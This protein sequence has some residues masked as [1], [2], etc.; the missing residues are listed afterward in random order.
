MEIVTLDESL[1][2]VTAP[3]V[4]D[5]RVSLSSLKAVDQMPDVS[6]AKDELLSFMTKN[7]PMFVA[8][9][10]EEIIG[11]LICKVEDFIVW[12]EQ[13]YVRADYRRRGVASRLFD[14][15][16]ALAQSMGEDT[17]FNNVHP[18][19]QGMIEFL[20]SRGY[21][22]LNLIEIRKAYSDEETSPIQVG[23]NL[24]EY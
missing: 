15:A 12:V 3:L 16:E 6:E 1:I 22:V 10:A 18:N 17:V 7:Y 9:E 4:A 23:D 24:L 14:K 19:N 2:D 13:F 11:Y 8:K 20:R 21:S 5:F